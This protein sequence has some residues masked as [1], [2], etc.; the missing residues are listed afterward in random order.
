MAVIPVLTD[1][2]KKQILDD[3]ETGFNDSDTLYYAAIGRISDWNDS[4][5]APQP[6]NS[7]RE[8][9][10]ARLSMQS[11]KNITDLTYAIPRV[12]WV[13]GTIY[14]AYDD[15]RQGYPATGRNFYAMN[16][17]QEIY[18][19]LQKGLTDANPPQEKASTVQ[20]T[21]NTDGTPFRTADGYVWK[22]LYS[23]GALRASKF[24]SAG[25]LPVRKVLATDSD[26]PAEDLQQE[27]VQNNAVVG[28]ITGYAITSGGTGY[29][30]A[31]TV[32]VQGNGT[33]AA[34]TATVAGGQVVKIEVKEDSAGNSGNSYYGNSYDYATVTL[35]GGGGDSAT[36]RAI[37]APEGG[38]GDDPR[39]DLKASALMFNTKP[40]GAEGGDFILGNEVFRQVLLVK[41]PYEYDSVG[42]AGGKFTAE[43][44]KALKKLVFSTA[45]LS[46][47]QKDTIQGV[48]SG[49]KAIVDEVDSDT[50]FYHQTED[51]GFLTFQSEVVQKTTDTNVNGTVTSVLDGEVDPLKGELLYIDNR[52]AVTRSTDQEEDIKIVIQI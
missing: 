43:T 45:S 15:A 13:S 34:A 33:N 35:S 14:E 5:V 52:A 11:V 31:P 3:I 40:D 42:G 4:D 6:L 16:T 7:I 2:L 36:A 18:I 10:N 38:L 44:G 1:K 51:T 9:R 28:Q 23:I 49:A 29:T 48:T 32:T 8:A 20:P 25:Y 12:N 39:V 46:F 47:Q 21:G 17:N 30:S 41:D 24:V 22:F 27:I 37:L 19:C 26:S 50:V